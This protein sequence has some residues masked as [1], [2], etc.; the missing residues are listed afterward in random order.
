MERSATLTQ[1]VSAHDHIKGSAD[2][3]LTLVEYGDY[4]CP[5]CGAA[6]P[7][8]KRLQKALQK[9]LRF[10][11]RNFPL[12]QA[13]PYALIA[14]E[15]AEAAALQDKFWEMH[16]L[17]FERQDLLDPDVIHLWAQEIGL[18]H[19][20][21]RNDVKQGIVQERI[22]KDRQNGILSGVNGTPTFF[23]NGTRYDGSPDYDSMLSV[24]E[25][26]L[27]LHAV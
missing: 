13:H 23:I 5:Y 21:F 24:L 19:E 3:P 1:P 14:A 7:V 11:F 4:Q 22:R 9:K 8:V 15:A 26:E 12:T 17:L 6:Y 27:V 18:N 16:D 2:A 25:S 20:K 10:V